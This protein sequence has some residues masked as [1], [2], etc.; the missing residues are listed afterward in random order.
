MKIS[1]S[2]GGIDVVWLVLLTAISAQPACTAPAATV[3]YTDA[4][5][6]TN[7]S[8]M[9]WAE[10]LAVRDEKLLA[11]G[12][13]KEVRAIAGRDSVVVDLKGRFVLPGFNDAHVHLSLAGQDLL[14]VQLAEV[15]SIAEM[16]RRVNPVT[17]KYSRSATVAIASSVKY[18]FASRNGPATNDC[19]LVARVISRRVSG[20]HRVPQ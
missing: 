17:G 2:L 7:D 6:Y 9:P 10:A 19:L 16:Q 13:A 1:F 3:L 12:S 4:R 15:P 20:V 11:V 18:R 5:I 8:A 14:G